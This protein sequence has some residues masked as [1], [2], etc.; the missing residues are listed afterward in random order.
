VIS[1]VSSILTPPISGKYIPGSMVITIPGRRTVSSL[2][3]TRGMKEKEMEEIAEMID[4][5]LNNTENR[6]IK[7]EVR[8]KVENLCRKFV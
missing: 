8:R 4:I 7:E 1:T 5:V 3:E 6:E 2:K